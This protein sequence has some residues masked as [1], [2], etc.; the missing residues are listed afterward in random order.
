MSAF[1]SVAVKI[2]TTTKTENNDVTFS[3]SLDACVDLFSQIGAIRG[4]PEERIR[5]LF[6]NAYGNDPDVASRIALWARDIRGGAGERR[7]FRI[8]LQYLLMHDRDRLLRLVHRTAEVGRWD[9]LQELMG[10]HG[11]NNA[12]LQVYAEALVNKNGLAAKWAPRDSRHPFAIRLRQYM[13]LTPKEY[14]KLI[15][16]LSNTVEQIMCKGPKDDFSS[17]KDINYSHVPSVASARYS[18]AFAK[19]DGERYRA[20]LESV[21][22][23]TAKINTSAAYPYDVIKAFVDDETANVMWNN[24]PDFVKEGQA[25]LPIIDV[26]GSMS[27]PAGGAVRDFRRGYLTCRDVAI[28]LGLYLAER[29]KTHFERLAI[30]FSAKPNIYEIPKGTIR[31]KFNFLRRNAGTGYNTNLDLAMNLVLEVAREGKISQENMPTHLLVL[32][33]MEFDG[34]NFGATNVGVADRTLAMFKEAGYN[35]P[36]IVWWN[37]QSRHG[38]TPVR[39]GDKSMALVSG[40]SPAI[41]TNLMN[42]DMTPQ[43]QMLET[44]MVD[45]YAH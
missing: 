26:S 11:L 14:R 7:S 39:A 45:R 23:G 22:K 17:W 21:K 31:E 3:S 33:D 30:T 40:F 41:M 15:V 42:S 18:K 43:A 9:D 1:K 35:P 28:S 37:I 6:S 8:I 19:R 10:E 32:S 34:N 13:G 2:G 16:G 24:L 36:N 4:Q 12:I 20:Y 27:A 38:N 29:N 44:V 25:F 5:G